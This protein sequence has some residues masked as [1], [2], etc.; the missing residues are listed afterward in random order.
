[1]I[2]ADRVTFVREGALG[3]RLTRLI[4]GK[5]SEVVMVS[6]HSGAGKS[7]LVSLGGV[8]LQKRGWLFLRCKFD[9]VG[10]SKSSITGKILG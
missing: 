10:E 5:K 2:A 6:G 8:G 7:R 4:S 9:R 3:D 1:M